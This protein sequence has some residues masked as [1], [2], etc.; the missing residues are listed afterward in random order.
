MPHEELSEITFAD[1]NTS[2]EVADSPQ[3]LD[4]CFGE[5]TAAWDEERRKGRRHGTRCPR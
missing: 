3:D 4:I 2:S 1:D 5:L